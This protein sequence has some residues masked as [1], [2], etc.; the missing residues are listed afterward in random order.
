VV[1]KI[2]VDFSFEGERKTMTKLEKRIDELNQDIANKESVIESRKQYHEKK[3]EAEKLRGEVESNKSRIKQVETISSIKDSQLKDCQE[4]ML[5]EKS[6]VEDLEKQLEKE[7][8]TF[9]ERQAKALKD[10]ETSKI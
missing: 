3:I 1:T 4:E 5:R 10:Y 9:A 6:K 7:K 2:V 8:K